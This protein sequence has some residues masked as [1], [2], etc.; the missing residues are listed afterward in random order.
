MAARGSP[1]DDVFRTILNDCR[2]LIHPLLNEIFG[3]RY[4][5]QEAIHFGPNEHFLE[6]QN[7]ESDRR[8]TD[9]SFT[10]S[11]IHLIRYHLECQSTVDSTMDRRFFEYDSQIALEDSEKVEDILTL[12]FPKSTVLF[13]RKTAS[14]PRQLQIQLKIVHPE[15]T[16]TWEIPIIYIVDYTLEELFDKNLLL[17]LPFHLFC[18]EHAFLEMERDAKKREHLKN[19]CANIRF[20]LEQMARKGTITEY[21]CRTILDLGRKVAE[22]L[23]ASYGTVKKEV[24]D[25]MGGKILEYEAKTI[26]NEG[27][28]QGWILGRKS[29]LAEGHNSGLAEGHRSGL[30][31]GRT[32]GRTETYLELIR[33]GI[34]NIADA[35]KRIPMEE[36]ELRK[37]LN[38]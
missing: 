18:Y 8:I 12:S 36:G 13:L 10:V 16:V 28:Q 33:D 24:L 9:S 25:I 15:K 23:C 17:L 19:I 32:E 37:L 3:E 6:R 38:K 2:S 20:R 29:G 31:E 21:I 7:G 27:K 34:L 14:A 26:L 4:S 1:Y 30:A 35:A 5:G 22:N 11:G